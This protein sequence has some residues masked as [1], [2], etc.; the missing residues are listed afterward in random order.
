MRILVVDD[1]RTNLLAAKKYL[2]EIS[3][4]TEIHMC[5]EPEKVVD[6]IDNAHIDILLL[7]IIM[8]EI[9]GFDIMQ[10][11]RSDHR[12]DHIPIIM[13]TS[14]SDDE[15]FKKCF[16][17]GAADYV[18]KPIHP[19]E[20]KARI[21]AAI[22][23]KSKA[24]K[25]VELL[26]KLSSQN[27]KLKSMNTTLV[28][29]Q[30]HLVQSEKMAAIG[31]L[32]AGIAHEINNPMGF[33]SSNA[34]T[35]TKYFGRIVEYLDAV[36][37][38]LSDFSSS[39]DELLQNRAAQ[40]VALHKKLKLP[41]ILQEIDGLLSDS[42]DGIQRVSKIV[43]SLRT[44]ARSVKDDEL[45]EHSLQ[46]LVN[47]VVLISHNEVKYVADILVNV[48]ENSVV[49]CNEVQLG[50]VLINI[51]V[52]AAQAIKSQHRKDMG[53][54]EVRGYRYFDTLIIEVT[55][56]GPGI[57]DEVLDKIF[58]PFFTTKDVGEGTGLGLSI[59][60]DIITNK[61]GGVITVESTPGMGTLFRI[62]LP[63]K[64]TSPFRTE[65]IL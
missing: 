30:S 33:V 52:N 28:E 12:Y 13:F 1:S 46:E 17:L 9:T 10:V 4:I 15:S 55:D 44:F 34:E 48:E 63:S 35:L 7:D 16:E 39:G 5:N 58:D 31:Q 56:D 42:Q 29:T 23:A 36:D 45:D 59:S 26:D 40:L 47:Q 3:E 14:L 60:Y 38:A 61:H 19:V 22:D 51:I 18:S 20:F 54:I 65:D 62:T 24:E 50:Q 41:I 2:E 8:P 32:S 11:L 57:P 25:L 37:N 43:Q 21:K 49:Y 53:R 27:N 6:I 64:T